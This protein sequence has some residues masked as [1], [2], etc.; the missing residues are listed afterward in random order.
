MAYT[1][2]INR[3]NPTC[4]LFVIDQS[5]SMDEEMAGGRVK[6]EFVADVLN[7]TLA[8]TIVRCTKSDGVRDYFD[9]GVVGYS[10]ETVASAFGGKLKNGILHKIS[11]IEQ[12]PLRIE[13]REVDE[14]SAEVVLEA[15][16]GSSVGGQTAKFPV[17][18]DPQNDGGTP[19]CQALTLVSETVAEWCDKHPSSYPPTVVHVTDGQS[20][21]GDPE[22][23]AETIK[24]LSTKDG[25]VL[26][27]NLHV[28]TGSGKEVLFPSSEDELPDEYGKLLFRMSSTFPAHLVPVAQSM[29]YDVTDESRFFAYKAGMDFIGHF[30][31]IGT[32]ASQLR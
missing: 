4:F 1:T 16:G 10:D 7:Q 31:E 28:D 25:D 19:M 21:D 20:T 18:I 8:E 26:L 13:E 17:W 2:A 30:F 23:I 15:S 27:F 5:G 14:D 22:D 29:G 12:N 9:I 3:K 11:E 6:S 24:S 32:R